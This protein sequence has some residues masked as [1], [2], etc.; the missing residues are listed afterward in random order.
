MAQQVLIAGM[1]MEGVPA[2]SVPDANDVWHAFTDTSDADALA[3]DLALGKTAYAGGVKLVGTSEPVQVEPLSVTANGTYTAPTGSAYSP[4]TVNVEG[5]GG[6]GGGG[7]AEKAVNFWDYDGELVT[8]YTADK[9]LTLD[10]MPENPDHTDV[11]LT[12]QGWN[13]ALADA[14]EY[15]GKYGALNVG[16]MYVPTDGKTHLWIHIGEHETGNALTMTVRYTQTVSQG[17][18][19]DWGDGTAPQ[20]YTGTTAANRTH[21]YAAPGDY[22]ITLEVTSGTVNFYGTSG[23]T[24]SSI[25]GSR[26]VSSGKYRIKRAWF[27]SGVVSIGTYSMYCCYSLESVIIPRGVTTVWQYSFSECRNLKSA[28]LPDSV[29]NLG[30]FSFQ[31]CYTLESVTIPNGVTS[32]PDYSFSSCNLKS[33]TLPDG[34]TNLGSYSFESCRSLKSVIIP[35][36][37]TSIGNASFQYCYTLESVTIPNGVTSINSSAFSACGS[38]EYHITPTTPPTLVGTNAFN[39]IPA[40]CTFYVPYSEDHSILAAYQA[41]SNWSTYASRMVEEPQ[42]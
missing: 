21:T 14:Q 4:V 10:A 1:L 22:E 35:R 12:A 17:V 42:S 7:G 15:V 2:I 24:G 31:Y 34:V 30:S 8:S 27:G 9:F 18:T 33:A 25:Y 32:I 39:N 11:G 3:A 40:D 29:T 26:S 16:Q 37:V 36:D 38:V 23:S 13:W 5:G 19:V 28:T 41:A 6:G 20:A